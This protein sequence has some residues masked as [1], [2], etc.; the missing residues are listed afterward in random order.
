[1]T[2]NYAAHVGRIAARIIGSEASKERKSAALALLAKGMVT[3]AIHTL[4]A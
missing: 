1:M 2:R 4:E 3:S